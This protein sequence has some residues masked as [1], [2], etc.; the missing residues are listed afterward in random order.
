M[1]KSRP[2]QALESLSSIETTARQS[3]SDMERMLG[4]LRH[5]EADAVPFGPQPGLDQVDR[6]AEQ[7]TDAGLPVDVNVAGEPHKLPKSLD[8]SAYRIVQEALTNALKHAGPTRVRV[9]ISYL[10]DKLELDIV[11]DGLGSGDNGPNVSGGRGLI[12]MRERVSL[13]GGELDVGF[14]AEGGFRVHA[15][16]PIEES[17]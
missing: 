17:P 1:F 2:D 10:A 14:A 16:L 6:L 11:D 9:A 15:S 12:G 4:I 3:L 8:L 5:T 7:F 13:F